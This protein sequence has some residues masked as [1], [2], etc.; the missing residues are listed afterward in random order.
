[1]DKEQNI[2]K[3]LDQVQ[4]KDMEKEWLEN[5]EIEEEKREMQEEND[6]NKQ[7]I[8]KVKI[9]R[10][11]NTI[12][13]VY[14]YENEEFVVMLNN[15]VDYVIDGIYFINKN[16]IKNIEIDQDII[17]NK[18][19]L[20]KASLYNTDNMNFSNF[21]KILQYLLNKQQLIEFYLDKQSYTS[22][23]RIISIDNK[24]IKVNLVDTQSS[25]L[26]KEK[27]SYNKI[28]VLAINT[29]YVDALEWYSKHKE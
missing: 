1:M 6:I 20:H 5:E 4:E 3:K 26:K 15:P 11:P 17:S 22:I 21:K 29:D 18:I 19:L 14:L 24:V 27:I 7:M 12:S 13:G 2:Q 25:F 9:N 10:Y 23:G 8:I 28:R 16:Y